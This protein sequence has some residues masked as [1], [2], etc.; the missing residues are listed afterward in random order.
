MISSFI[1]TVFIILYIVKYMCFA[2]QKQVAAIKKGTVKES[3]I[4]AITEYRIAGKFG[5]QNV[6]RTYSF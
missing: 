3:R 4:N 6:W 1:L 2:K 5:G